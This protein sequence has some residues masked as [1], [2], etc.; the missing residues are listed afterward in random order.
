MTS[1]LRRVTTVLAGFV[2][3]TAVLGGVE[4]V[5]GYPVQQPVEWLA[6][7]PFDSYLVPG[8]LL[9]ALVGGSA[10]LA[11]I[12]AIRSDPRWPRSAIVA[13]VVLC[14]WIMAEMVMLDQP[15]TPTAAEVVYLVIGACLVLLGWRAAAAAQEQA[16]EP[17]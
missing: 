2:G 9:A 13:G 14:G 8:L 12:A 16:E 1:R 11:F 5:T 17:G 3:V 4:L 7:T 15:T 10:V 6:G